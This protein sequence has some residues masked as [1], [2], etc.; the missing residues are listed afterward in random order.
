MLISE[1]CEKEN[2]QQ[3]DNTIANYTSLFSR[4]AFEN[5]DVNTSCMSTPTAASRTP[6]AAADRRE[7]NNSSIFPSQLHPR[8]IRFF[9]LR[10]HASFH[11]GTQARRAFAPP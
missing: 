7:D 9:R 1:S 8:Q 3:I 6:T 5:S 2:D 4:F 11:D 10:Q